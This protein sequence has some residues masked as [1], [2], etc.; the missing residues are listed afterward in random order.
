M[1]VFKEYDREAGY[2]KVDKLIYDVLRCLAYDEG[3]DVSFIMEI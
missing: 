3:V 1:K 2:M